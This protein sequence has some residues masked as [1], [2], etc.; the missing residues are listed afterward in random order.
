MIERAAIFTAVI[1][2]NALRREAGL[3]ELPVRDTYRRN[4]DDAS[5][6]EFTRQHGAR[7]RAE[8]LAKQRA[9]YGADWPTSGGG[10]TAYSCLVAMALAER[11]SALHVT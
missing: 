9:R 11:F 2:K 8:V 10:R 6:H 3:P 4:V 7:V 5:W 1:K